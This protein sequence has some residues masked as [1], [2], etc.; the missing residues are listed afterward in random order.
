MRGIT[1]YIYTCI[2]VFLI[3]LLCNK[4]FLFEH[5][6]IILSRNTGTWSARDFGFGVDLGGARQGVL[7][8]GAWW[9]RPD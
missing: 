1:K 8:S 7:L 5:L 3:L 9:T 2:L 6:H 4:E